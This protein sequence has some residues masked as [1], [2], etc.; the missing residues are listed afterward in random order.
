[1][2]TN[3]LKSVGEMQEPWE[4]PTCKCLYRDNV[5]LYRQQ[6]NLPRR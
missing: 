5:L 3:K 6:T 2:E 1:M 4:T